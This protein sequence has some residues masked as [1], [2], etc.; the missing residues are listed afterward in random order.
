MKKLF[1]YSFLI[2]GLGSLSAQS[3]VQRF[4]SGFNVVK[5]SQSSD[6]LKI[7]AVLVDFQ[8]DKY[9]GTVGNGKFGSIYTQDYGDTIIDP[10]PHDAAYFSDHLEFAKN[11]YRKVSNGKLNISYRVLPDII[12]VSQT[13]REYVPDYDSKDLSRLGNFA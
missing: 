7:L 9:D 6:S 10:L 8:P 5:N 2:V 13:M 12:T 1:L 11:Y 3:F 4:P